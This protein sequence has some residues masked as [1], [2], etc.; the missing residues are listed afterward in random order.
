[1]SPDDIKY[2]ACLI[3]GIPLAF[4]L[5][6]L[7][8]PN[9]KRLYSVIVGI[10]CILIL[11][12]HLII[13][14]VIL[15]AVS[16]LIILMCGKYRGS[17]TFA[18][19]FSYLLF[20]RMADQFGFD[21][22]TG[23]ANAIQLL[24]TLRV[25]SVAFEI[26][27]LEGMKERKEKL[28][29][30]IPNSWE[31]FSY[32]Y[33]FC[34]AMTGPYY[35]YEVYNAMITNE[36][37]A[38]L[39]TSVASFNRLSQLV[40]IIV[41]FLAIDKYLPLEFIYTE[42]FKSYNMVVKA[43]YMLCHTFKYRFRFYIAWLLA[44]AVC[45][46][47]GFGANLP[48]SSDPTV[49]DLKP[50]ININVLNVEFSD[51]L[52]MLIRNWNMSVQSWLLRFVYK[53]VSGP[54]IA[55]TLSTLLVSAFWHGVKPGYYVFFLCVPIFQI[56]EARYSKVRV[57]FFV[58]KALD[59]DT[60]FKRGVRHLVGNLFTMNVFAFIGPAFYVLEIQEI[61]DIWK[62]LDYYGFVFAG[63]LMLVSVFLPKR[64]KLIYHDKGNDAGRERKE[65][66]Q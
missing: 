54:K 9:S 22:P 31:Y 66:A 50:V 4:F 10:I 12:Q 65:K 34:G 59:E 6:M 21:L 58:P 20:C 47:A 25:V 17:V 3:C 5:R 55:R 36:K 14:S 60:P 16:Y 29:Y 2:L 24:M 63:L 19:A 15:S 40:P 8:H 61:V 26:T 13:Y 28:P 64:G 46:S 1:M 7:V 32:C 42:Q 38:E 52:Q 18:F 43:F 44:E 11:C 35:S 27:D 56:V 23:H 45:I 41:L 49:Q 62:L 33:C 48:G 53:R 37:S 51:S 57:P 39:R 30:E